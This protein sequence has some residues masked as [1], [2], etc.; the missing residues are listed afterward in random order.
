MILF[1]LQ[2]MIGVALAISEV[3]YQPLTYS[4]LVTFYALLQPFAIA[5]AGISVAVVALFSWLLK[6]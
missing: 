6:E 1:V 2:M 3:R 5:G 4:T